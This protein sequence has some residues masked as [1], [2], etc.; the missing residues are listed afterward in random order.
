MFSSGSLSVERASITLGL[1]T[2]RVGQVTGFGSLY[3]VSIKDDG[4][5]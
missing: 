5:V 1:S 3:A 4:N 2:C